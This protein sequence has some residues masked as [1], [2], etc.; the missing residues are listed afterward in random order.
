MRVSG[1]KLH[2]STDRLKKWPKCIMEHFN[3]DPI[4]FRIMLLDFS[5]FNAMGLKTLHTPFTLFCVFAHPFLGFTPIRPKLYME[6]RKLLCGNLGMQRF[7]LF[8]F[9]HPTVYIYGSGQ[10]SICFCYHFLIYKNARVISRIGF[11][12]T[13]M[14]NLKIKIRCTLEVLHLDFSEKTSLLKRV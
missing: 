3:S 11:Y 1:P 5:Y 13:L 9:Q 10:E 14:T 6:P 12:T 8:G 7:E 2:V 4:L